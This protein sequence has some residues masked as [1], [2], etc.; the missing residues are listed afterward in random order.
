MST[1]NTNPEVPPSAPSSAHPSSPPPT[2]LPSSVP[3]AAPAYRPRPSAT[4][5]Q[6][7]RH[8]ARLVSQDTGPHHSRLHVVSLASTPL[9][10]SPIPS[11]LDPCPICHDAIAPGWLVVLTGCTHAF[12]FPCLHRWVESSPQLPV[13]C[14]L[15]RHTPHHLDLHG[16]A[17]SSLLQPLLPDP[18][19]ISRFPTVAERARMQTWLRHQ[20]DL[21]GLRERYRER[22]RV[23]PAGAERNAVADTLQWIREEAGRREAWVQA[24]AAAPE[25]SEIRG[26]RTPY[27]TVRPE[28]VP[29]SGAGNGGR[30]AWRCCGGGAGGGQ[31]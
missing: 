5:G 17:A 8:P 20:A 23:L 14:P 24:V 7:T 26:M 16:A 12:C 18:P 28:D 9:P 3:A 31:R 15:C 13:T 27:N 1:N 6:I 4:M 11:P 22:S 10:P 25:G 21:D 19:A 29:L 30:Q 2:T